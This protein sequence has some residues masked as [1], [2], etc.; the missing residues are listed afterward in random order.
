MFKSHKNKTKQASKQQLT[1]IAI[2]KD[3]Y[4]RLRQLGYTGQTFNDVLGK[5]LDDIYQSKELDD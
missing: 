3:N 2:S 4:S 1:S 5:I